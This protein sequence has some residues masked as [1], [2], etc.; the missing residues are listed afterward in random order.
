MHTIGILEQETNYIQVEY[1][2]TTQPN[3]F[4]SQCNFVKTFV[5]SSKD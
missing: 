2:F 1:F 3:S 5:H 4:I